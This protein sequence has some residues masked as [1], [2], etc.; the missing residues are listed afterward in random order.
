MH[1][2]LMPL[3]IVK[4]IVFLV[5][6]NKHTD[7]CNHNPKKK[8][9]HPYVQSKILTSFAKNVPQMM[10]TSAKEKIPCNTRNPHTILKI[11]NYF[12]V[13]EN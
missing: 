9:T 1:T 8:I 10:I 2:H 13:P 5:V 12:K 11:N 3:S 4:V 6:F 7:H